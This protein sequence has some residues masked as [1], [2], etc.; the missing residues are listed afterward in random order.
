M[1]LAS[2]Q[3]LYPAMA[4]RRAEN[5]KFQIPNKSQISI[6]NNQTVCNLKFDYCNL[7][8]I[9]NLYLGICRLRRLVGAPGIEPGT[10][11]LSEKRSNQLSYAPVN[12][13]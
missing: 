6:S 10:S 3:L 7:F 11:S 2:C 13:V 8:G 4:A 9:W 5:S 12:D 1:G